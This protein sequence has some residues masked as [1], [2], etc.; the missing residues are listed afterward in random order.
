MKFDTN[1]ALAAISMAASAT[2]ALLAPREE[3]VTATS[4]YT[5]PP[6]V[7][8]TDGFGRPELAPTA[9][10]TDGFGRPVTNPPD[11]SSTKATAIGV[12][13][14]FGAVGLGLILFCV[15]KVHLGR[16]KRARGDEA[17][18]LSNLNLARDAP[19]ARPIRQGGY[20]G[21]GDRFEQP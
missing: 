19:P 13:V 20:G 1:T 3:W 12:G 8:G 9:T 14:T 2:G 4:T 6:T 10:G 7:T 18:R 17:I 5:T 16:R 21:F 15:I 11:T